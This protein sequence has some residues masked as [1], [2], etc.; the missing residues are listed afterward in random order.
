MG[1]DYEPPRLTTFGSI[2]E[3]TKQGKC[4]GKGSPSELSV[5]Y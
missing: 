4:N 1:D 5:G 3:V 2:T